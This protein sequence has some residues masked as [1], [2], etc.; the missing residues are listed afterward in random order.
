MPDLKINITIMCD[1]IDCTFN[2]GGNTG[3]N[4]CYE[5]RC[6]HPHPAIQRWGEYPRWSKC[7]CNSKGVASRQHPS[8]DVCETPDS[9]VCLNCCHNKYKSK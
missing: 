1:Q 5:T 9:D 7:I 6:I 8:C 2:R 4:Y 3:N